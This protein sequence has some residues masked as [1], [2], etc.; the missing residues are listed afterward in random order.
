MSEFS[1]HIGLAKAILWEEAKGKLRAMAA[2]AGQ[3]NSAD[4]RGPDWEEVSRQV[5]QFIKRFE[6]DGLH[7]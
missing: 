4:N 1:R 5:E 2:A 6:D 7:E 3:Q